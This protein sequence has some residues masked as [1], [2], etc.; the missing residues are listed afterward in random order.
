MRRPLVPGHGTIARAE[1]QEVMGTA[2]VS[3]AVAL[4]A[5]LLTTGAS[6]Q[7]TLNSFKQKAFLTCVSNPGLARFSPPD[8]PGQLDEP[9]LRRGRP[10]V[11]HFGYQEPVIFSGNGKRNLRI[12]PGPCTEPFDGPKPIEGFLRLRL[13]LGASAGLVDPSQE[14][15]ALAC[16]PSVD[17]GSPTLHV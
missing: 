1:D 9:R 3:V 6:A 13:L 2:F 7:A 15:T 17:P 16:P 5:G 12:G 10:G 4:V 11:R 8:A 14:A